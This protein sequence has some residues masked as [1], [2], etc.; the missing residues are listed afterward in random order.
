[1]SSKSPL[2]AMEPPEGK[3]MCRPGLGIEHWRHI[4]CVNISCWNRA[5]AITGNV[6][7]SFCL[8]NNTERKPRGLRTFNKSQN[9]SGKSEVLYY[10]GSGVSQDF[11]LAAMW[12]G[13]RT[14]RLAVAFQASQ[15]EPFPA[16]FHS[17]LYE[18]VWRRMIS[19]KKSLSKFLDRVGAVSVPLPQNWELGYR[20]KTPEHLKTFLNRAKF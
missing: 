18:M 16:L 1:M 17:E 19:G 2:G 5:E 9:F 4:S 12:A 15:W 14:L 8:R 3:N 6:I 20:I 7:F 11:P 13:T 10:G